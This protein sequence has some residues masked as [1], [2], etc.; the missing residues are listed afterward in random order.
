MN[1]TQDCLRSF[2]FQQK[3]VE[4]PSTNTNNRKL[5]YYFILYNFGFKQSSLIFCF[6]RRY[7]LFFPFLAG[8]SCSDCKQLVP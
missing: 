3:P 8:F 4:F 2:N 5:F 1:L 6:S 7:S